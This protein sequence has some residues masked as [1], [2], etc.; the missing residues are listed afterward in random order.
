[1]RALIVDDSRFIRSL[2]RGLLEER[3]IICDEAEDGESGLA[4]LRSRPD[5]D[6]ALID[7]NM[8][9]MTG[10]EMLTSLRAE[11]F[12]ELK[13]MIVTTEADDEFIIQALDRGANEYLMKPF[14]EQALADKLEMLGF[15]GN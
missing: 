14:D 1:M 9:V 15:A 3:G 4:Q 12:S 2:V 10:L 7:W 11:G 5:F 13:V 6:L 8:P